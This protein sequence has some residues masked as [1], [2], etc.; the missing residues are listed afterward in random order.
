LLH[1]GLNLG[2]VQA[3]GLAE[4]VDQGFEHAADPR[5]FQ[6]P[7]QRGNGVED[8]DARRR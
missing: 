6:G 2:G 1:G 3:L 7:G 4:L 5:G 8:P